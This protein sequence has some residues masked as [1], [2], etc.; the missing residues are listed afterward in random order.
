MSNIAKGIP[1]DELVSAANTSLYISGKRRASKIL[2]LNSDESWSKKFKS[3]TQSVDNQHIKYTPKEALGLYID[4]GNTSQVYMDLKKATKKQN[5]NILPTYD[6]YCL[7]K[8]CAILM[9]YKLLTVRSRHLCK[10]WL[11]NSIHVH[12]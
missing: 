6:V 7:Q 10:V 1:S 5:A 9:V 2:C 8:I 4:G 3:V 11:I 12:R